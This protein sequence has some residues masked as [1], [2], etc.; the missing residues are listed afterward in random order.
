MEPI[1]LSKVLRG[2]LWLTAARVVFQ[3]IYE[4]FKLMG[5]ANLVL[6]IDGS[7]NTVILFIIVSCLAGKA[8]ALRAGSWVLALVGIL[9]LVG[10]TTIIAR[11]YGRFTWWT[12]ESLTF[13]VI[14]V[15]TAFGLAR[16][17]R[18]WN[19]AKRALYPPLDVEEGF[20]PYPRQDIK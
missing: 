20:V 19:R 8:W 3:L 10:M 14:Q 6:V 9:A 17:W 11:A 1:R 12:L 2:L 18:E 4:P 5:R 16:A 13:G 7:I 15:V